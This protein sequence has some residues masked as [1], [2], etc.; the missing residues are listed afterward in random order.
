[1]IEL[2]ANWQD[3]RLLDTGNGERLE[4]WGPYTLI[5]PDPMVIWPP[6]NPSLWS[7]W[8]GRYHRSAKGGGRWEFHKSLPEEWTLN[9]QN[10]RFKVRPTNFKHTGLFPEQAA[11]WAWTGKLIQM[12]KAATEKAPAMIN[13]FGY[14]GAATVA[15]TAAGAEVCHVDAAK[16][17][18]HWCRENMA[19]NGFQDH[20]TRYLVEDCF[21]FVQR[22]IRRGRRYDGIILDP[23]SYGRGKKGEM[24]KLEDQLWGFLQE[25]RKLL[26]DDPLFVLLNTY[27]AHLS[28][29]VMQNLLEDATKGLDVRISSGEI[30]LPVTEGG[31]KL[32]CGAFTRMETTKS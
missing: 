28:P 22:E 2:A 20:P 13:L 29:G 23:P 12:R 3:Y 21:R 17:M 32:P 11:N 5:R 4:Q 7:Q 6:A 16:G 24:W 8:D 25:I 18:V 9:Y 31:R 14:T 19:L 1:M 10:L 27:T 15:A 30:G 26:S